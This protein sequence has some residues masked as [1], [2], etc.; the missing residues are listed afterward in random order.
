MSVEQIYEV[1]DDFV[2]FCAETIE[3]WYDDR[4][5]DEHVV[6]KKLEQCKSKQ[7][8]DIIT[9][10]NII[11]LWYK[12]YDHFLMDDYEYNKKGKLTRLLAG[13]AN[14]AYMMFRED[15][16]DLIYNMSEYYREITKL[17]MCRHVYNTI[18]KEE[19]ENKKYALNMM[20]YNKIL[21]YDVIKFRVSKF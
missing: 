20:Y 9:K 15:P 12:Y 18:C 4:A 6:M 5:P 8:V 13:N 2:D 21:P 10:Y 11:S 1:I 16:N 7:Y 19:I 17:S 3:F 14:N